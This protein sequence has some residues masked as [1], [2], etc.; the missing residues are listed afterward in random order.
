MLTLSIALEC[1]HDAGWVH[2]DISRGNLFLCPTKVEGRNIAKV[3]LADLELT[4]RIGDSALTNRSVCITFFR[5]TSRSLSL[6]L[7]GTRTY[8]AVEVDNRRYLFDDRGFSPYY[9]LVDG[10]LHVADGSQWARVYYNPLHDLESLWWVSVVLLMKTQLPYEAESDEWFYANQQLEL[11]ERI[12]NDRILRAHWLI[13]NPAWTGT[14][15]GEIEKFHPWLRPLIKVLDCLRIKLVAA[16]RQVEA[17]RELPCQV[18]HADIEQMG[19]YQDFK[20][21][22][23]KV[24]T[25]L[26]SIF[27]L[28]STPVRTNSV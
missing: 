22:M 25:I 3:K 7:Q 4:K 18:C 17:G 26:Q 6:R 14:L 15:L 8:M 28:N 5:R 12:E 2:C 21:L 11:V 13:G 16:Y 27:E 23:L 10:Q 19:L 9:P 24:H 1:L 20:D